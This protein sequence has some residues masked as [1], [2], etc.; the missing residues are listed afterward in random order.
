MKLNSMLFGMAAFLRFTLTTLRTLK[1]FTNVDNDSKYFGLI[2]QL[3]TEID[4]SLLK[5]FAQPRFL[6]FISCLPRTINYTH[7]ICWRQHFT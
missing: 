7:T 5:N 4:Q 1:Q 6:I 2:K 3:N